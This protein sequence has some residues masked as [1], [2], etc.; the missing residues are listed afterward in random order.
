MKKGE[1][2]LKPCTHPRSREL[3]TLDN[4][5]SC[6]LSDGKPIRFCPDCKA[7]G[8]DVLPKKD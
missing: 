1:V 5:V 2:K 3:R 4:H 8:A 7:V 6:R